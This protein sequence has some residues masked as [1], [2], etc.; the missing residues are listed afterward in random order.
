MES[1][2]KFDTTRFVYDMV[3]ITFFG[4]LFSNITSGIMLD[5]FGELRQ[6]VAE[7]EQD[8]KNQC[9]I[10]NVTRE[11]LEKE[12]KTL[13]DHI[14]GKH[15]LWNYVFFIYSLEKKSPTDYSGLEYY[16]STRYNRPDEDIDISWVP[17]DS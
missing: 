9:Y 1:M 2:D 6:K 5:A 16:I 7:L 14:A 17:S 13:Q 3:Y 12:S 8:K 10:C 11:A 15:F 4:L